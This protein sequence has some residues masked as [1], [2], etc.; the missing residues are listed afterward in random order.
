MWPCNHIAN[1]KQALALQAGNN[2]TGGPNSRRNH[3]NLVTYVW[4]H[5]YET[6]SHR[7]SMDSD[8]YKLLF[9]EP[10][11]VSLGP[12]IQVYLRNNMSK[13]V[14]VRRLK[15]P[16]SNRFPQKPE[17]RKYRNGNTSRVRQPRGPPGIMNHKP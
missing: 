12:T 15:V 4:E 16:V 17:S 2:Q 9:S 7:I 5:G 3:L 6:E 14:S 10:L 13:S 1:T 8:I 11:Q